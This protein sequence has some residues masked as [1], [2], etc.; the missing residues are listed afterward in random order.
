MLTHH[1]SPGQVK[2]DVIEKLSWRRENNFYR[3]MKDFDDEV[4]LNSGHKKSMVT[5][6]FA[7]PILIYDGL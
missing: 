2:G 6:V 1:F 4:L 7:T 5:P 3:T